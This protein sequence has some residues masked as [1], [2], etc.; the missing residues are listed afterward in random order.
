MVESTIGFF[1]FFVLYSLY[2]AVSMPQPI[3]EETI[4]GEVLMDWEVEE[5]HPHE[6]PRSWV[7]TMVILGVLLLVYSVMSN[8]LL[9]SAIIILTGIILFLQSIQTPLT[10]AF[11]MTEL[12]IVVGN[13]FYAYNELIDFYI[14]YRPPEVK[15]LYLNTKSPLRPLVRIPVM[16]QNPLMIRS[17]LRQYLIENTTEEDEPTADKIARWWQLH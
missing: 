3:T 7:I 15:Y 8:N 13:R 5:Y 10:V 2:Y 6:H 12:G 11:A 1:A 17:Y 9:F 4:L 16:D 14:V